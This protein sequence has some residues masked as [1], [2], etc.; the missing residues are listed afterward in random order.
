MA[1]IGQAGQA[2]PELGEHRGDID[3]EHLRCPASAPQPPTIVVSMSE[4]RAL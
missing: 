1:A 3:G 2:R 4:E